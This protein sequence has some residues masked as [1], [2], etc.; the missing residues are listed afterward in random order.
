[1]T[2]SRND[3]KSFSFRRFSHDEVVP[4]LTNIRFTAIATDQLDDV[5]AKIARLQ[6]L[7]T[8]LSRI[9]TACDGHGMAQDCHVLAALSD[10][11]LCD[12]QH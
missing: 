3:T 10:H 11:D 4:S 9:A 12:T 7:E 5:R 6:R 1:M 2:G 8:E